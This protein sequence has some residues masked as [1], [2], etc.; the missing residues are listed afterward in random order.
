MGA[1]LGWREAETRQWL[2]AL[3]KGLSGLLMAEIALEA[4]TKE[5]D[6][7]DSGEHWS[8][9]TKE[10]CVHAENR[11]K[12]GQKRLT[13]GSNV[14]T[15]GIRKNHLRRSMMWQDSEKDTIYS[16]LRSCMKKVQ[17]GIEAVSGQLQYKET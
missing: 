1:F 9:R 17:A 13:E 10:L 8:N 7:A 14:H 15:L 16:A 11:G 5:N 2:G 3:Q 12:T 6:A 4:R